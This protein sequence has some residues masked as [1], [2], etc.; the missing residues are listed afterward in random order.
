MKK[1]RLFFVLLVCAM[2]LGNFS[3]M[4]ANPDEAAF[5]VSS[6]QAS[7]G[8]SVD[9]TISVRNNPGIASAKLEVAFDDGL[10]LNSVVYNA[11]MGGMTMQ[12]GTLTSPVILN[13]LDFAGNFNGDAVF[14]TLNFT[15]AD[16]ASAGDYSIRVSYEEDNVYNIA[17][18]NIYFYASNGAV[19]VVGETAAEEPKETIA[20]PAGEAPDVVPEDEAPGDEAPDTEGVSEAPGD[21]AAGDGD[22]SADQSGASSEGQ[23]VVEVP[24]DGNE[25]QSEDDGVTGLWMLV[26]LLFCVVIAGMLVFLILRAKRAKR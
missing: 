20:P 9:I 2:L 15:V 13:W 4:A 21:E 5:V 7:A 24:E 10:T 23:A 26:T 18:D 12:P 14:A 8:E 1:V 3:A 22:V 19:T 6:A 17:E 16:H 11:D 25:P